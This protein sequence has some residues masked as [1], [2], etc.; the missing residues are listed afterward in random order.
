[1]KNIKKIPPSLAAGT[2][3]NN[4]TGSWRHERPE[5]NY[6]TCISCSM[7]EKVCP[8]GCIDMIKRKETNKI[9]P[10]TDYDYCKGCG[11]CES[12]CPVKAISMHIEEK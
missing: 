12:E 3:L 1:M 9:Q 8:E 10:V 6:Q 4:K 11:I 7:C 5:T 2:S